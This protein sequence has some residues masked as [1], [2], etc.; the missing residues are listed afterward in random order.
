M[1]CEWIA[2]DQYKVLGL[3]IARLLTGSFLRAYRVDEDPSWC[4]ALIAHFKRYQERARSGVSE[5]E[6]ISLT[7]LVGVIFDFGRT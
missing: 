2:L 3:V 1:A 5:H 7:A 4:E 6:Q